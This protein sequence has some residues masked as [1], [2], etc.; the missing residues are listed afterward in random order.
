M[1]LEQQGQEQQQL[2]Q[3]LETFR[4]FR[5]DGGDGVK[6]GEFIDVIK[7][8]DPTWTDESLA[9]VL[10]EGGSPAAGGFSLEALLGWLFGARGPAAGGEG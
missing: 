1:A 2:Q 10:N 4:R 9:S 6:R 8:L 7:Y 3:I 5:P